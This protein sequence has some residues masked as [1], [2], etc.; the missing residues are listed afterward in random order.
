ML[1]DTTARWCESNAG[2]R[3]IIQRLRKLLHSPPTPVGARSHTAEMRSRMQTHTDMN[4]DTDTPIV[5]TQADTSSALRRTQLLM[6]QVNPGNFRATLYKHAHKFGATKTR[7]FRQ[8]VCYFGI[9]G[10][11]RPCICPIF[12]DLA[13]ARSMFL[14]RAPVIMHAQSVAI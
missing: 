6:E 7:R 12:N 5:W 11:P 13:F 1:N 14:M 8:V 9:H 4:T 2:G 10:S 3:L